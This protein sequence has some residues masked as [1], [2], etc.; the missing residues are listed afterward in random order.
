MKQPFVAPK[1]TPLSSDF[2]GGPAPILSSPSIALPQKD[3]ISFAASSVPQT[4]KTSPPYGTPSF[5]SEDSS[6]TTR[7]QEAHRLRQE[8]PLLRAN[9]Q[10]AYLDN[11][12]TTQ[13]PEVVL[14]A[15]TTF[16]AEACANVHRAIYSLGEAATEQYEA[17]RRRVAAFI[18]ARPEE[19]IFTR[20]TT[21]GFNLLAHSLGELLAPGDEIILS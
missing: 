19:V 12:A 2:Q 13:K 14:E 8:F 15:E 1:G 3:G 21:E 16:Y 4:E 18:G 7:S 6:L 9:P 5:S 10:L 11:A 17:A 20:G